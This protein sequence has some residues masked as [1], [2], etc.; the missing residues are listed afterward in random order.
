MLFQE[1]GIQKNDLICKEPVVPMPNVTC[2]FHYTL[3][4]GNSDTPEVSWNFLSL[5][6]FNLHDEN[7]F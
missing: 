2:I 3:P 1:C 4:E 7:F 5:N 6:K